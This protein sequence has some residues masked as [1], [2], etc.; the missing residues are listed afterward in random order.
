MILKRERATGSI[1][2]LKCKKELP[3]TEPASASLSLLATPT[4]L[5]CSAHLC[6]QLPV[7]T[8]NQ[9]SVCSGPEEPA[10][11]VWASGEGVLVVG[12]GAADLLI[13]TWMSG[14]KGAGT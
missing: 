4:S 9:S 12:G 2:F 11:T 5:T 7:A 13:L 14:G 8:Y 6:T 3:S 10:E 1:H